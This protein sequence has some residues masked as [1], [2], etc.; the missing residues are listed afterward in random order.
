MIWRKFFATKIDLPSSK[1]KKSSNPATHICHLLNLKV[2]ILR[3]EQNN[4]QSFCQFQDG[5]LVDANAIERKFE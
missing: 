4:E 5:S 2:Q 3:D 1:R